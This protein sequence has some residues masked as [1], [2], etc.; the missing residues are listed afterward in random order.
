MIE[1]TSMTVAWKSRRRGRSAKDPTA[2]ASSAP[3]TAAPASGSGQ[4]RCQPRMYVSGAPGAGRGR[5]STAVMYAPMDWYKMNAK[6]ITP[7]TPN[8][9]FRPQQTIELTA[10]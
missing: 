1:T 2:R 7:P 4:G 8:C 3:D 5:V 10:R 6:F 9:R